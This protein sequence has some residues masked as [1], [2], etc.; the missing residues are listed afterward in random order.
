MAKNC[1]LQFIY[2]C[3]FFSL[4]VVVARL[5]MTKNTLVCEPKLYFSRCIFCH[6]ELSI[7]LARDTTSN[8]QKFIGLLPKTVFCMKYFLSLGVVDR[9]S[10]TQLLMTKN[11]LV[12][13]LRLYFV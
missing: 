9:G 11:A 10:E 8:D 7:A 6:L 5:E 13:D 3:N 1:D 2:Q 12:C 4:A